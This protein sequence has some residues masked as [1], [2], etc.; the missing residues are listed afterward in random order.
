MTTTVISILK[1]MN[2]KLLLF[3]LKIKLFLMVM[4]N[5]MG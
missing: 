4:S 1:A 2:N 3:S 5:S